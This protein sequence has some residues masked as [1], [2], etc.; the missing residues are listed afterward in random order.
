MSQFNDNNYYGSTAAAGAGYMTGSPFGSSSGS[1]GGLGRKS[2]ISHSLRPLTIHQLLEA[3]Q[4]HTDADWIVD[5]HEIGQ[6]TVVAYISSVQTQATNSQYLLDDGSGRIEARRWID[7]SLEDE[8][9]QSGIVEGAYVRVSGSLKTFGSKRYINAT[10]VRPVKSPN[11]IYFHILEA[12]TITLIWERGPPPRPGESPKTVMPKESEAGPS[13][14]SAQSHQV[15]ANDQYAHLP[16]LHQDILNFMSSQPPGNT[17]VHVS[18]IARAVGGQAHEISDALDKIMDD[19]LVF[20]TID[21]SHFQLIT[22]A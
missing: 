2:E 1:P 6:V 3:S 10:H 8:P 16:Q 20:T 12:M 9:E 4:P 14:Y 18:A 7:S 17:G 19:G 15:A 22:R 5:D 21:E 11:E 13:A